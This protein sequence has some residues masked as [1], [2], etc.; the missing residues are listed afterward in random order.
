MANG[1]PGSAEIASASTLAADLRGLVGPECVLAEARDL[2]AY[3]YDASMYRGRPD[4]VVLP[5]E[6]DQVRAVLRYAVARG[7]PIVARGAGTSVAG[8]PTAAAGGI[9]LTLSRLKRILA[10]DPDDGTA[11][12]E[13]GVT[14][15]QLNQALERLGYFYAPDPGSQKVSTIGGNAAT[16]AGGM[17]CLKYGVTLQNVVGMDVVLSDG[18]VVE[19]GTRLEEL[20]GYDLVGLLVGSEGTLALTTKVTVRILPLPEATQALLAAFDDIEDAGRA[21]TEVIG[22]GI[23][24]A[25]MELMDRPIIRAVEDYAHAGYPLDAEAVLVIDLDGLAEGLPRRAEEVAGVCRRHRAREVR[26]ARTPEERQAIWAGRRSVGGA[27]AR[28]RP[29]AQDRWA[30]DTV[31]RSRMPEI[32]RLI[33]QIGRKYHFGIGNVA[34]AGD[35]N[36]HPLFQFD[37]RDA[38]EKQRMERVA[39]EV[40]E[41]TVALGGTV[42]GEHGVGAAP[43]KQ[44]ALR[45]QFTDQELRV[46]VRVKEALDPL[47]LLNPGKVFPPEVRPDVRV[48][49]RPGRILPI[50][51][52]ATEA[53]AEAGS[54]SA[55]PDAIEAAVAALRGVL[56]TDELIV[57]A[58]VRARYAVQGVI[59]EVVARPA[60]AEQVAGVLRATPGLAVTPWGA[61]TR[62]QLGPL[63][64]ALDFVLDVSC[65][66]RVLDFD[67]AS[68]S[69]SV[70]AGLSLKELVA[71][72]APAGLRFPVEPAVDGAETVGGLIA[73]NAHGP[74]RLLHRGPKEWLLAARLVLASGEVTRAGANTVKNS[75]AYNLHRLLVGSWGT[76]GIITGATLRL[77]PRP[78][79][80]RTYLVAGGDLAALL[81]VARGIL[82]PP[83]QP[84]GADLIRGDGWA[85]AFPDRALLLLIAVEGQ[86]EE[87]ARYDA[88]IR[89]LASAQGLAL[90]GMEGAEEAEAWRRRAMPLREAARPGGGRM[91]ATVSARPSRMDRTLDALLAVERD[92]GLPLSFDAH[93]GSGVAHVL[94]PRGLGAE[95][96]RAWMG[97]LREGVG[98]FGGA[99]VVQAAPPEVKR[100]LAAWT[101]PPG[102]EIMRTIRAALDPESRMNPG[103]AW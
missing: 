89:Q 5:R 87:M 11:T 61:G 94:F 101:A 35:G 21:A 103:R 29:G 97:T 8:G 43:E 79:R 3:A 12:V 9:C 84:A 1:H 69:I 27:S 80:T 73:A 37:A 36:V 78:E 102:V 90:E 59:P 30:D 48:V 20:P 88:T 86:E 49:P 65:L 93:V 7:I 32:L 40:L 31:P 25:A 17:H 42:S 55:G 54:R 10:I 19:A 14:N 38:D 4:V 75:A 46:M 99:L 70:E 76:L 52:D 83:L 98:R 60:A 6:A 95:R 64:A 16:N 82:M 66:R 53:A 33:Q 100:R 34:H 63:P 92:S 72:V 13:P 68:L 23:V 67:P 62:Q 56:G 2:L 44:Q 18:T 57:D 28:I 45:R 22:R 39:T 51:R 47:G 15:S 24:P 74:R 50:E 85:A 91:W 81:A 58:E 41:A 26:V 71:V 77:V 96:G